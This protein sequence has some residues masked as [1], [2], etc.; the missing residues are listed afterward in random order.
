MQ[1]IVGIAG[2]H[3]TG[4]STLMKA[5]AAAAAWHPAPTDVSG[6]I[7]SL[8]MR[9]DKQHSFDDR[10][11]I[12]W[13]VLQHLREHCLELRKLGVPCVTD[14]T[15]LD[16]VMYTMAEI[17]PET[18]TDPAQRAEVRRYVSEC[19]AVANEFFSVV[20]VLQPGIEP[21]QADMKGSMCDAYRDHLNLLMLG[22]AMDSRARNLRVIIPASKTD[23]SDRVSYTLQQCYAG[24]DRVIATNACRTLH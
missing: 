4:K 7:K 18:I 8:G 24:I 19:Y 22:I 16:L 20:L 14:R 17:G 3:R 1:G 5:L 9:A 23:L 6:V 21:V 11:K 10:M 2:V 15:P 13:A 12:Q